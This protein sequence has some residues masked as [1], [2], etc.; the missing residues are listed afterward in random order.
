TDVIWTLDLS[1]R[2]TYMSPAVTRMR[3]YSVEEVMGGTLAETLAPA[4]LEVAR[5]AL[6]EELTIEKET[7]Q[8]DLHR[9][10]KLELEMY[11]KDGSTIWTEVQVTFL[12]DPD[13]RP[14]GILGVT[15]DIAERK[16]AEEALRESEERYR[17]L[18]DSTHDMIQSAA[19]DGRL[20]FANQVWLKTL[21]YTEAELPALNLLD[22]IHPE[23]LPH[24]RELF[25]RVMA[26][27]S[28]DHVEATFV[29]KDGR[30]IA[31]EGH[32]SARRV[33]GR[34]V[35]T[36]GFFH[37]ITDR[38]HAEEERERLHA[39]L[40]VRAITDSLT[41]LYDHAHFYQRLA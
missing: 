16:Q 26:G 1:L 38:K 20:L 11:C 33:G 34:V 32:A 4:S 14:V 37:D 36:H 21:G 23:S 25:T 27:E 41:G 2:Y 17:N 12:R 22:I 15:R 28:A 29:A 18:F 8:K 5:K 19:P 13:G 10:R 40:Q 6:A 31:V 39:E 3:G 30:P 24:C 7:E 9:S 35:A